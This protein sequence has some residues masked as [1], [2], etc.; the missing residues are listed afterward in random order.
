MNFIGYISVYHQGSAEKSSVRNC[1]LNKT[2]EILQK[3]SNTSSI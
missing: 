1:G 2:F 3:I